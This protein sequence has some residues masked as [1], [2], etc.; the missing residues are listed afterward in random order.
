MEDE[1]KNQSP[2]GRRSLRARA[3]ANHMSG[4][5]HQVENVSTVWSGYPQW[6]AS[7]LAPLYQSK[8][9]SDVTLDV[10]LT[11]VSIVFTFIVYGFRNSEYFFSPLL[12]H[13]Y[14]NIES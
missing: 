5:G 9:Y 13:L 2:A 12:I 14:Y 11:K 1:T 6:M 8:E 3:I 10:G 4:S 7:C